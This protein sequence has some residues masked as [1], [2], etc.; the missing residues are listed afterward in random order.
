M[1]EAPDTVVKAERRRAE[2]IRL[3]NVIRRIKIRT[4]DDPGVLPDAVLN[5]P[6]AEIRCERCEPCW[7]EV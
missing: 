5:P 4:K 7:V 3:N 2:D 1:M 6:G